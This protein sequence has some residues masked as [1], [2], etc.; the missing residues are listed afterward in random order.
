MVLPTVRPRLTREE[1]EYIVA[2][3]P[4]PTTKI[5]FSVMAKLM[6]EDGVIE[7]DVDVNKPRG[8]VSK[9]AR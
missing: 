7:D 4:T 1:V 3:L 2:N 9:R 8:G 6:P 5:G